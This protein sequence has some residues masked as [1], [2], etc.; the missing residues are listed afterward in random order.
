MNMPTVRA[1]VQKAE[2]DLKVAKDQI[3]SP[4]PATDAICFHSQQCA[5]KYLKAFL[6]FHHHPVPRTHNIAW[7]IVQCAEIDAEFMTLLQSDIPLL[8]T[9]A[10]EVRYPDLGPELFPSKAEAQQAI[11]LAE[12]VRAF[13]LRKIGAHLHM[14]TEPA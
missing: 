9:Y 4:R 12:Q 8:S 5:E 13:V 1:W 10:V 7:L 6:V 11:K 14:G 2:N 3:K